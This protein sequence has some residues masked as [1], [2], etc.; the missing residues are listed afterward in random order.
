MIEIVRQLRL[1]RG[2]NKKL[3]ILQSHKDN[4][5]WK[6]ILVAMYDS[7]INYYV[8]APA[9][10]TFV[11]EPIDV[12]NM[13]FY[14]RELSNR[15]YTGGAARELAKEGSQEFGEIFRLI[16]GGSLKAGVSIKTINKA[17]P[18][19]IPTFPV[20]L[21]KAVPNP[22]FPLYGSIKYDGVRVLAFVENKEVTLKTRA[23]KELVVLS[24]MDELSL[25][26]DGVYDGELVMGSGKQAGR[27]SITGHVNKCLLGSTN[28]IH[29]DY[30]YQVFD[31]VSI[32]D[33]DSLSCIVPFEE[34]KHFL[35][36]TAVPSHR[37]KM[38]PQYLLKSKKSVE[39]M[40]AYM[41]SNG[42]EGLIL[43]YA[44]DPY[45]WDRTDKLIKMKAVKEAVVVC[46]GY[47]EGEGKY[48]GM[49]GSLDCAGIVEDIPVRFSVGTGLSDHDRE[50][51]PEHY[52]GS[53]IEITYN[54]I[55]KAEGAVTHSL[56]IPVFKR[57]K[58]DKDV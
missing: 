32:D 47:T 19:L 26:P 8:G 34:R 27:T 5:D 36:R 6:K 48:A 9:D 2:G 45:I 35:Y 43:R 7:S 22:K 24:L 1:A 55:V 4:E 29:A 54:D 20:M 14:L 28:E 11:D 12:P 57:R 18:G 3:A 42:F 37:V 15:S 38:V 10:L 21:A 33:W 39:S 40:F 23:G 52:V 17:Y 25:Y 16:L 58:V 56:F 51:P 41:M 30:T 13:M 44:E 31:R 50:Q 53:D 49:I 46:E